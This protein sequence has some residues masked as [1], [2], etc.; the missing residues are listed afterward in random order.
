[1]KEKRKT[2]NAKK[3]RWSKEEDSLLLKQV[4]IHGAN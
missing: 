1:M 4:E 3:H 2:D